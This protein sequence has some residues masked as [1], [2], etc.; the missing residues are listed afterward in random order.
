[1]IVVVVSVGTAIAALLVAV[2]VACRLRR[3]RARR[4]GSI[5]MGDTSV[6]IDVL[7]EYTY[8][9]LKKATG[10]F[11]KEAELGRGAFGV[12]YKVVKVRTTTILFSSPCQ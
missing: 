9:E 2:V 11:S 4:A 12:V 8:E 7:Q 10:N 5:I 3:R 1:V 6:Q